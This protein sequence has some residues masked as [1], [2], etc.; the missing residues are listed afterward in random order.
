MRSWR[1]QKEGV[2]KKDQKQEDQ[3]NKKINRKLRT[4]TAETE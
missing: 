1:E 2:Q 4:K 3:S